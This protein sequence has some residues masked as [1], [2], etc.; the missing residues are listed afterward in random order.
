[1]Y[2]YIYAI[3]LDFARLRKKIIE[4]VQELLYTLEIRISISY[5]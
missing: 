3:C 4:T 2:I 1:M 5:Y